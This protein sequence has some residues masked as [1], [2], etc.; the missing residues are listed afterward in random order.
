MPVDSIRNNQCEKTLALRGQA[1][2]SEQHERSEDTHYIRH[3]QKGGASTTMDRGGAV[4]ADAGQTNDA[5]SQGRKLGKR[6]GGEGREGG[7]VRTV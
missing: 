5:A 7:D 3:A 4:E 1:V 6:L 2:S